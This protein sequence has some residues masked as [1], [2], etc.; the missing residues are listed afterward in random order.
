MTLRASDYGSVFY[1]TTGF[2]GLHVTRRADRVR[3]SCFGRRTGQGS[4]P[5]AGHRRD[6]RV[7]LLA[8]RRHRLDRPVHRHLPDPTNGEPRTASAR[9]ITAGDGTRRRLRRRRCWRSSASWSPRSARSGRCTRGFAPRGCRRDATSADRSRARQLFLQGCASLPR[10]ERARAAPAA[11]SLIGVGAA[12]VDFQVGTGRMPLQRATAPE[13]PRKPVRY[14]QAQTERRGVRRQPR[15]RARRSRRDLDHQSADLAFGGALFRTNCAQCHNFAGSG[16]ALTYGKYAP[17]LSDAT[18]KQIYEAMITGPESM[19]V[20]GDQRDHP[21]TEA[22]RSSTTS[23]RPRPSRTPAAPASA[24]SARSPRAWSPS[25]AA[26]VHGAGGLASPR[27]TGRP[28]YNAVRS[29]ATA[30]RPATS[31]RTRRARP[32]PRPRHGRRRPRPGP[33]SAPASRDSGRAGQPASCRADPATRAR[34][35]S[36]TAG[37]GVFL[38]AMLARIGFIVAYFASRIHSTSRAALE[39]AR[40]AAPSRWRSSRSAPASS[41]GRKTAAAAREGGPG[42]RTPLPLRRRPG[43]VRGD[44]RSPASTPSV[45]QAA[46]C[47]GAR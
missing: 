34:K 43:G 3:L 14:S 45:R 33:C 35:R 17:A 22:R 5:T 7:L 12:A 26:F 44:L 25:S 27:S 8:L 13:A 47:C 2:H 24:G 6:R 41:S 15:R 36:P 10:P 42:A 32:A 38:I 18:P 37:L 21:G 11:P 1:L 23:P 4:R 16:G 28:S 31:R 40:W 19:P 9:R 29:T 39:H 30:S 46:R 20:F